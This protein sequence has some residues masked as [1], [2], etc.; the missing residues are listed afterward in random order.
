MPALFA[1]WTS[2]VADAAH[3]EVGTRVLDIAC[4]K[5]LLARTVAK[6]V[7]VSGSVV[8]VDLNEG[9]LAVAERN[10]PQIEWRQG[11]AEAIPFAD[12]SFNAVVSQFG[13]MF[14]E[15]KVKAF[16]RCSRAATQWLSCHRRLGCAGKVAWLCG[17]G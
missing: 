7:G 1:E 16:R 15:D 5:G 4:G 10:A 13:L 2:R 12:D 17:I 8:G 6:R 14:F 11:R 3:I 9:M